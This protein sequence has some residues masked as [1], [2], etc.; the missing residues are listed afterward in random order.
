MLKQIRKT[1]KMLGSLIQVHQSKKLKRKKKK[2]ILDTSIKL[3][4]LYL[5]PFMVPPPEGK[6]QKFWPCISPALLTAEQLPAYRNI[7][8]R[9]MQVLLNHLFSVSCRMASKLSRNSQVQFLA[10]N[11]FFRIF[12]LH[13]FLLMCFHFSLFILLGTITIQKLKEKRSLH[14]VG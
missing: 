10:I 1:G 4:Y 3:G 7:S 12:I 13:P 11:L 5:A 6:E 8:T 2:D 9:M 14:Y